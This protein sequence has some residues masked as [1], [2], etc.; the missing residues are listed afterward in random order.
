MSTNPKARAWV[1]VRADALR[2]NYARVRDHVGLGTGVLPMVKADAYGLG[3]EDVVRALTPLDPWGFGVAAVSEGVSLRALGFEGR[4]LVCSPVPPEDV[5]EAVR[6]SLQLSISSVDA[7]RHL[8]QTARSAGRIA[9]YH[10]DVDTGMGRSG[11]DGRDAAAWV[12]AAAGGV[13]GARCAGCYTHLHSA[14]ENGE[15]VH[16]QWSLFSAVVDQVVAERGPE[17]SEIVV[18]VLNSAG[19]FR[20]SEVARSVVRPGIFLYGGGS[21]QGSHS[22]SP[23]FLSSP[24]SDSCVRYRRV[25]RSDMAQRTG[26]NGLS[27][28]QLFAS[29]TATD[30][31]E[32]C[33]TEVVRYYTVRWSPSSGGSR[34]M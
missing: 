11:F 21:D 15:T 19:V 12:A 32:P 13:D 9:E 5:G 7:L 14:D 24:R 25:L 1:Q 17:A 20:A 22:H 8:G 6:S 18:H 3:A 23:S 4:I 28:G 31:R 16:E 29:G 2:D 30:F 34:W 26:P 27:A 33:R 10:V